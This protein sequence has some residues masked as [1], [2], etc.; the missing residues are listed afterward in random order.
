MSKHAPADA[1]RPPSLPPPRPGLFR[2]PSRQ[3][4]TPAVPKQPEKINTEGIEDIAGDFEDAPPAKRRK[5]DSP[6]PKE[7]KST[8]SSQE[9]KQDGN[10]SHSAGLRGGSLGSPAGLFGDDADTGHSHLND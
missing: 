5:I 2:A 6:V 4:P 10:A 9:L 8:T 1:Q 7:N 3:A